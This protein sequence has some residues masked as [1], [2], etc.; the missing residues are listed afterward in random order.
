MDP[1]LIAI[2]T[3]SGLALLPIGL[4]FSSRALRAGLFVTWIGLAL[5]LPRGIEAYRNAHQEVEP[6]NR[7][8]ERVRENYLGSKAC[9]ACHPHEYDT[10]KHTWHRTMTQVATPESVVADFDG[11][12][13]DTQGWK[14]R[15]ER[16][17]DEFF[18]RIFEEKLG[19]YVWRRVVMTTGS[20]HMQ[21]TGMRVVQAR[22]SDSCN[23]PG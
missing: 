17:G 19:E 10:W 12:E 7:P 6:K 20:H 15:L 14:T 13:L 1:E 21:A 3:A 9:G 4:A 16:R 22:R 23:S 8:I 5:A 2:I 18:A 11:V